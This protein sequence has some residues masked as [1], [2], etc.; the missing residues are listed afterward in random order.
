MATGLTTPVNAKGL[1]V[2]SFPV[3]AR[4]KKHGQVHCS[5][6]ST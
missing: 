4:K 1:S 5:S 2:H 6:V 3:E